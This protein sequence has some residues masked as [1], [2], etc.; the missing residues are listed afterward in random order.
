MFICNKRTIVKAYFVH[1]LLL[2]T[3][4]NGV[5]DVRYE[6][7]TCTNW[8]ATQ[9]YSLRARSYVSY[10]Y[11]GKPLSCFRTSSHRLKV[12]TGKWHKPEAIPYNERKC[13]LL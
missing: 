3:S 9:R 13:N 7:L 1:Y 4:F 5:F 12:E 10:C 8:F 11:Y 6:H 2:F